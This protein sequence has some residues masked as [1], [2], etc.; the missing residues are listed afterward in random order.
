MAT[1]RLRLALWQ[2]CR[3]LRRQATAQE[4]A[5][6]HLIVLANT[7]ATFGRPEAARHLAGIALR[8][9]VKAICLTARANALNWQAGHFVEFGRSRAETRGCNGHSA[10]QSHGT[11]M[12]KTSGSGSAW[13]GEEADNL[14]GG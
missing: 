5:A 4:D 13:W 10:G 1:R 9:R 3:S 12:H 8:F 11:G 2:R 7:L 6:E 14:P